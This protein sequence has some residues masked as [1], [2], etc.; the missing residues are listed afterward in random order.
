M[1][2]KPAEYFWLWRQAYGLAVWE[3]YLLMRWK[4]L[5][6][7]EDKRYAEL[8]QKWELTPTFTCLVCFIGE[9]FNHDFFADFRR[10][11]MWNSNTGGRFG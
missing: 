3:S 5:H 2:M 9:G 8:R 11:D 4:S 6:P 10:A 7:I 1:A